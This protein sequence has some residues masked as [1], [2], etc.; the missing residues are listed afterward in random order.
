MMDPKRVRLVTAE[1]V[2]EALKWLA[3]WPVRAVV[4]K[5]L[6]GALGVS[7]MPLPWGLAFF[8]AL[9]FLPMRPHLTLHYNAV[10]LPDVKWPTGGKPN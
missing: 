2:R 4:L 10:S 5:A 1:N 8:L 9:F 3:S 6:W 7:S